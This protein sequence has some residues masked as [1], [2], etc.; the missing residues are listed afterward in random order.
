MMTGAIETKM[1]SGNVLPNLNNIAQLK[2]EYDIQK[3]NLKQEIKQLTEKINDIE[4]N[5]V[6]QNNDGQYIINNKIFNTKSELEDYINQLTTE[7]K[8]NIKQLNKDK[9]FLSNII[10]NEQAISFLESSI[11]NI[12]GDDEFIEEYNNNNILKNLDNPKIIKD[13]NDNIINVN[14]INKNES[15]IEE[16]KQQEI[17]NNDYIYNSLINEINENVENRLKKLNLEKTKKNK[18]ANTKNN[19]NKIKLEFKNDIPILKPKSNTIKSFINQ[20]KDEKYNIYLQ[21]DKNKILKYQQLGQG[22]NKNNE[23]LTTQDINNIMFTFKY[24]LGCFQNDKIDKILKYIKKNNL[25]KFC[26]ILNTLN[27]KEKDKIGHWISIYGDL[28]DD[29]SLEYYDSFGNAPNK[30]LKNKLKN[31]ILDIQPD[32]YIKFKINEQK[33]QSINSSLCGFFACKFL[34]ERLNGLEFKEITKYKSIKENEK[35][36]N[37]FK[38]FYNNFKLI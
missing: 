27:Y 29:L 35:D 10:S 4:K 34:I 21:N 18:I 3:E 1:S 8:K 25:K 15:I 38:K 33:E 37:N 26:F 16:N 24:Y 17:N 12:N 14:D 22:Y 19:F 11:Y 30:E 13:N 9:L 20:V 6:I 28:E 7:T 2:T 23:S 5:K 36:I 32:Y 31:F